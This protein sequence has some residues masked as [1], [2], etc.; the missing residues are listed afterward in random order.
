M[1]VFQSTVIAFLLHDGLRHD[2][3]GVVVSKN[4]CN[5]MSNCCLYAPAQLSYYENSS[6]FDVV[7]THGMYISLLILSRFYNPNIMIIFPSFSNLRSFGHHKYYK[8]HHMFYDKNQIGCQEEINYQKEFL[9][10]SIGSLS[11]QGILLGLSL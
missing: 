7:L 5:F 9:P 11:E 2:Y 3:C 1:F 10:L 8:M 6:R 4:R